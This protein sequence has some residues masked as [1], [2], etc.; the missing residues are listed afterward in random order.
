MKNEELVKYN[1]KQAETINT[2]ADNQRI[3]IDRIAKL[4]SRDASVDTELAINKAVDKIVTSVTQQTTP[5]PVEPTPVAQPTPVETPVAAP[6]PVVPK[7]ETVP[8]AP[9]TEKTTQ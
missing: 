6:T 2:I 9:A 3:L 5:A 7:V 8:E 4:E 1:K